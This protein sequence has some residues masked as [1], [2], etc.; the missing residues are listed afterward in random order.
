MKDIVSRL[1]RL[2]TSN[3]QSKEAIEKAIQDLFNIMQKL[4][5][6]LMKDST[7]N[8]DELISKSFSTLEDKQHI[9]IQ[10]N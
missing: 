9:D 6:E 8:T 7:I 3:T 1:F 5:S 10:Y 2:N 4:H